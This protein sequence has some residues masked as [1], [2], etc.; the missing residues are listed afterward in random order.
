M[1]DIN[2]LDE[3]ASWSETQKFPVILPHSA[4]EVATYTYFCKRY[5]FLIIIA[6]TI[7]VSPD[8]DNRKGANSLMNG[9][10]RRVKA[11]ND[12]FLDDMITENNNAQT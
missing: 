4:Q 3:Y 7:Q 12:C 9:H 11:F 8:L 5:D 2:T 1:A 6:N 10:F